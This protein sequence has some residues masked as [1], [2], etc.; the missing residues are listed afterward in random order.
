M[1]Q[2]S[3]VLTALVL[4]IG[5]TTSAASQE[6]CG[7]M[8]TNGQRVACEI[9]YKAGSDDAKG[10]EG[11]IVSGLMET[12]YGGLVVVPTFNA[13]TV[14]YEIIGTV[15]TH[16]EE[17]LSSEIWEKVSDN[18]SLSQELKYSIDRTLNQNPVAGYNGD[19][20]RLKIEDRQA[21]GIEALQNGEW[22]TNPNELNAPAWVLESFE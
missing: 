10:S 9:G 11:F 21:I 14:G 12:G 13:G 19:A 22:A 18:L 2:K 5:G 3:D 15:G 8:L 20:F 17:L 16:G 7:R 6:I 1:V 4:T